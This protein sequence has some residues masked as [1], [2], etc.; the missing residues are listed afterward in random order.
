MIVMRFYLSFMISL[1]RPVLSTDILPIQPSAQQ[2]DSLKTMLSST[3]KAFGGRP[4]VVKTKQ[5]VKQSRGFQSVKSESDNLNDSLM[6]DMQLTAAQVDNMISAFQRQLGTRHR[7]QFELFDSLF[8]TWP[9]DKPIPYSYDSNVTPDIRK[10]VE[11][12]IEWWET[13]TCV[14]FTKKAGAINRL[15]FAD[16]AGCSSYVG[17]LPGVTNLIIL[18]SGYCGAANAA[19]EIA[20]SLGAIHEHQRLAKRLY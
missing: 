16:G 5:L 2:L 7:R 17:M 14:Q 15:K 11:T 3:L 10:A 12:A 20:H 8:K 13:E 19:H 18:Q 6:G 9:V 4:E 1:I